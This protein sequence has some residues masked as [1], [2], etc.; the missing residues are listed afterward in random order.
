MLCVNCRRG[1]QLLPRPHRPRLSKRNLTPSHVPEIRIMGKERKKEDSRSASCCILW[2]KEQTRAEQRCPI[3]GCV[4]V[5]RTCALGTR[6]LLGG[7]RRKYDGDLVR[8]GMFCASGRMARALFSFLFF[9]GNFVLLNDASVLLYPALSS[10]LHS[11]RSRFGMLKN[12]GANH[13]TLVNPSRVKFPIPRRQHVQIGV[14]RLGEGR[15]GFEILVLVG[16]RVDCMSMVASH[17]QCQWQSSPYLA[18]WTE[19]GPTKNILQ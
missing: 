14:F 5:P 13:G 10:I 17:G 4:S 12:H 8:F 3:F 7:E 15:V 18:S 2:D 9:L 19:F 6:S 11:T 1:G 16:F